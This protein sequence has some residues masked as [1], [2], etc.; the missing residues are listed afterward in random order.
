MPAYRIRGL[1]FFA[2]LRMDQGAFFER[3]LF[4]LRIVEFARSFGLFIE[5]IIADQYSFFGLIIVRRI[6]YL[7][8]VVI[9]MRDAAIYGLIFFPES[10]FELQTDLT[11]F[12]IAYIIDSAAD[13]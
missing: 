11:G 5:I 12:V 6:K 2:V 1:E 13:I 9:G 8:D 3:Q 10:S 4:P 7:R